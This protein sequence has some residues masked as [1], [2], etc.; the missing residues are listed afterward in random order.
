M[1]NML[2]LAIY[3]IREMLAVG[4]FDPE[5]RANFERALKKLDK[6]ANK[7]RDH[8]EDMLDM[9]QT[10]SGQAYKESENG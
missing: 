9:V 3:K 2:E 8:S 7:H 10:V 4:E 6:H 1:G 5:H